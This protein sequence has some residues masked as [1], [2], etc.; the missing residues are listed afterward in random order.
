[1]LMKTDPKLY[2]AVAA[3]LG[4]PFSEICFFD[5]NFE[6]LKTCKALGFET[7]G[8]YDSTSEEY[9]DDI[10]AVVDRYIISFDELI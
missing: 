10:K 9:K 3:K 6:V 2:E 4:V 1:M 7:I 8:V 5:D